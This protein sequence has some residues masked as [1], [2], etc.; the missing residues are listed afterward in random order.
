MTAESIKSAPFQM[1]AN[2]GFAQN[3]ET[4]FRDKLMFGLKEGTNVYDSEGEDFVAKAKLRFAGGAFGNQTQ[5]AEAF[6]YD[7]SY[8]KLREIILSYSINSKSLDRTFI[9]SLTF[10]LSG[11]NLWIIDKNLPDA[12]PEAG[13][14]SGNVQGYQSGVMPSE[15][16]YSFNVKLN[17]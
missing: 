4:D 5:P 2:L 6:I 3:S 13:N 10:S 7:A 17:F 15:K 11:T 8:V 14:S 1:P 12:D 9:K 16:V